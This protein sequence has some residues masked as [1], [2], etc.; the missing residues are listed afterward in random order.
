[1]ANTFAVRSSDNSIVLSIVAK[2]FLFLC[3]TIT[4]E[5]QHLTFIKFTN[6]YLNNL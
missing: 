1:M 2:F 6:V 4:R 3:Y 5:P